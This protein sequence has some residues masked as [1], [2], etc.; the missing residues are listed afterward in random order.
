MTIPGTPWSSPGKGHSR[1]A[2]CARAGR[3]FRLDGVVSFLGRVAPASPVYE[4]AEIVVVPSFGEG[5]GMVALGGAMERGRAVIMSAV[6]GLLEIVEDGRTGLLVSAGDADALGG[7]IRG[8]AGDPARAAEMEP[9]A[10]PARSS[11]SRRSAAPTASRRSTAPRLP[12]QGAP[13]LRAPGAPPRRERREQ[14]EHEVPGRAV[15]HRSAKTIAA[16]VL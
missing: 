15:A 13:L 5:F 12:A 1:R 14:C 2:G 7:A 16:A 10:E 8:L 4:R 6:G 9:R 11:T 3:G